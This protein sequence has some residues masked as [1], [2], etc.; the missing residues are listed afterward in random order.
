MKTFEWTVIGAGPAGI[1]AVG[2][3]VDRGVKPLDIAWVDPSFKVGDLGEKWRR[4]S[5]NTKVK[6]FLQFLEACNAYRF[7]MAPDFE[8][9]HL[10]PESTCLLEAIADPLQWVSDH[11]KLTVHSIEGHVD[12]LELCNRV[13]KVELK[14]EKINSKNVIL[15]IGSVPKKLSYPEL[16]EIPIEIAL[17]DQKL[18]PHTNDTVAVFGSSHSSMIILKN[19]LDV[20]VKKVINFY[21][22]PLKYALYME[23]WIL[24]DNTGLKGESATWARENINGVWPDRLE[25]YLS[26]DPQFQQALSTC[27]K[28]VYAVGFE[29]RT[30]PNTPQLR[31]LTYNDRNG[32]IAPGLFGLGI[33]FPEKVED[34]FGNEEYNVGIW[35]FMNYLNKVLPL[36]FQYAP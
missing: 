32:I 19:L 16:E 4:I 1:A 24:F 23:D 28:V 7:W 6:L 2:K 13:W 10:D 15:A 34:H 18:T 29:P 25:R 20:G 12:S 22:S 3:L 17:D 36:W 27:N 5:S 9:K 33:A 31:G 14:G 30:L 26:S 21:N 35:K 8:L 11:L